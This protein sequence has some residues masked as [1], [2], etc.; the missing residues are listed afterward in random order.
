MI[1]FK[2]E[3]GIPIPTKWGA[4]TGI[5]ATLRKMAIGDS[6]AIPKK[7]RL[8]IPSTAARLGIKVSTRSCSETEIRVWRTA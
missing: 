6:I 7:K 4:S 2:I 3:S 8:G 1:E 5:S